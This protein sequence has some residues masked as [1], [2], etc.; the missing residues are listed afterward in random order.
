MTYST[1]SWVESLAVITGRLR[2]FSLY[3][4]RIWKEEVLGEKGT[5][6]IPRKCL[7][8]ILERSVGK[9]EIDATMK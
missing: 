5:N 6:I 2:G 1:C 3:I 9:D 4:S 8:F 7:H